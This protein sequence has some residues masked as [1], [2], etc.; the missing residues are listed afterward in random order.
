MQ[1]APPGRHDG[2]VVVVAPGVVVAVVEE[3]G[4]VLVLRCGVVLLVAVR[5]AVP[6][7]ASQQL[8]TSPTQADPPFRGLHAAA[9]RLMPHVRPPWASVRQHVT[10]P[11]L[12]QVERAAHRFTAPLQVFGSAPALTAAFA[13]ATAHLT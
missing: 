10:E 13:K 9:R 2:A 3:G 12:P 1:L 5:Q 6:P 7:Q 8:A 4:L 11:G